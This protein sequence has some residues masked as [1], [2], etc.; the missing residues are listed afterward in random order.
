MKSGWNFIDWGTWLCWRQWNSSR[1]L[2]ACSCLTQREMSLNKTMPLPSG[3]ASRKCNQYQ[4]I[5]EME[6]FSEIVK[7]NYSHLRTYC[8]LKRETIQ[9]TG[10]YEKIFMVIVNSSVAGWL[11]MKAKELLTRNRW[12]RPHIV[13]QFELNCNQACNKNSWSK[14]ASVSNASVHTS[15]MTSTSAVERTSSSVEQIASRRGAPRRCARFCISSEWQNL[16]SLSAS[17]NSVSAPALCTPS[18]EGAVISSEKHSKQIALS[19]P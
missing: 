9:P 16:A 8:L 2:N 14:V 5:W 19:W 10:S 11:S 15:R 13:L 18:E 7:N 4:D 3:R 1:R 6:T 17:W 12:P